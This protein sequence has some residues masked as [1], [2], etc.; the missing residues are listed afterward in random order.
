MAARLNR[1]HQEMVRE[2][3]RASQL[4]NALENHVL[5]RRKM[6]STQVTAALGL[7]RK[8]VP[9]MAMVEHTGEV[10]HQHVA[11]LPVVAKTTQEWTEKWAPPQLSAPSLKQ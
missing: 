2:K 3:I 5:G 8:I 11:R 9:D 4:I 6:S 1:R 7:L 10:E